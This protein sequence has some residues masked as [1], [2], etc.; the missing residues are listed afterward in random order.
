MYCLASQL[1][2]ENSPEPYLS[3]SLPLIV[4]AQY[5]IAHYLLR[6]SNLPIV[7]ESF[8]VNMLSAAFG[9]NNHRL[10]PEG[11]PTNFE[12][13]TFSQKKVLYEMG[14]AFA[15]VYDG[16]LPIIYKSIDE[17][18]GGKAESELSKISYRESDKRLK[19]ETD[20]LNR[21]NLALDNVEIA[22]KAH[23]GSSNEGTVILIFGA[24]H[25]F[26]KECSERGHLLT[27]ISVTPV[28]QAMVMDNILDQFRS[29]Q[30]FAGDLDS[31]LDL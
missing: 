14:A 21:E 26:K 17:E 12:Q 30:E 19:T 29:A 2:V 3:Y 4:R 7:A 27:E 15:L 8:S 5:E 11:L 9:A 31:A 6:N 25:D 18:D 10:F 16:S 22:A 23:Y 24:G 28:K 20:F 1:D 13:L